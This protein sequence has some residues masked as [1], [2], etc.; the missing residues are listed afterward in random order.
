MRMANELLGIVRF[1]MCMFRM[2]LGGGVNFSPLHFK[3]AHVEIHHLMRQLRGS[4]RHS[5]HAA[6]YAGVPHMLPHGPIAEG[7]CAFVA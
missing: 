6:A 1:H 4:L 3:H 7:I 5:A 2:D